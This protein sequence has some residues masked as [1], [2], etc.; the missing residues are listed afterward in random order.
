[1]LRYR[2]F[3]VLYLL[4]C[5]LLLPSLVFA[6]SMAGWKVMTGIG[7][8][9][10]MVIASVATVN[11][12]QTRRPDCLPLRLKNW[13]FLPVWMTSL[14]PL[15]DL[16]TRLTLWCRQG[17][18]KYL[19]YY[20]DKK[21]TTYTYTHLTEINPQLVFLLLGCGC[22]RNDVPVSS[23]ETI[24]VNSERKTTEKW[25]QNGETPE[26]DG[27][28]LKQRGLGKP[29]CYDVQH[30]EDNN[31]DMGMNSVSLENIS[32][33]MGAMCSDKKYTNSN[34]ERPKLPSTPL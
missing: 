25:E 21:K 19:S 23:L 22:K 1:M 11:V 29:G 5:F 4:L 9:V 10:I 7:V 32:C 13:D 17:T 28:R 3:A 8:P 31:K 12:L 26:T 30:T 16:I 18:G 27:S 15:D 20:W 34:N 14:Q 33:N 24:N 6:L 2:W